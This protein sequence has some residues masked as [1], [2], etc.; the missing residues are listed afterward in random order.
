M[1]TATMQLNMPVGMRQFGSQRSKETTAR[2]NA[3]LLYPFI[4][5][6]TI[7]YGRAAEILGICKE[8]LIAMYAKLGIPYINLSDEEIEDELKMYDNVIA[9]TK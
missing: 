7:S 9:K 2:K 1:E 5:D 6:Y 4:A 8:R 3:M